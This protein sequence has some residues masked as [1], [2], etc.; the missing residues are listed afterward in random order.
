MHCQNSLN[1][2]GT[3]LNGFP[4]KQA[5]KMN[6][7]IISVIHEILP[8]STHPPPAKKKNTFFLE[9]DTFY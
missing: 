7:T 3:V 8:P 6:K 9:E 5:Y 4:S 1:G 2:P